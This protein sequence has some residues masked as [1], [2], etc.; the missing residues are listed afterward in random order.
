[1]DKK[2]CCI[3]VILKIKGQLSRTAQETTLPSVVN[4]G[5]EGVFHQTSGT[6]CSSWSLWEGRNSVM[7]D[8][9]NS[10]SRSVHSDSSGSFLCR[11]KK[12][13]II[14]QSLKCHQGIGRV[15]QSRAHNACKHNIPLI[16]AHCKP[17]SS[18]PVVLMFTVFY[19]PSLNPYQFSLG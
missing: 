9:S 6:P 5:S 8:N 10:D 13:I 19:L 16:S 12:L 3:N 18:I 11:V 4:W 1:M 7:C 15:L 2:L 14:S 17:T